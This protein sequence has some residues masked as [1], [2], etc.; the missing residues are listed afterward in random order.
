MRTVI[1]GNSGSGKTWLSRELATPGT[2][3]VHL[4]DLFWL[5][6][7]FNK[8]RSK[9]EINRLIVQS[10]G[11]DKWI[12]EG[13]FGELAKHFLDSANTLIWLDLPW[14]LCRSRLEQRGSESKKHLGREQSEGGLLELLEWASHY[15]N[16]SDLRSHNGHQLLFD[17]FTGDKVQL[18]SVHEVDVYMK[19]AKLCASAAAD[20]PRH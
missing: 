6:G 16:R 14:E 9:E 13:V 17:L 5:P 18:K 12:A 8:K 11:H 4:D 15:Y 10:R 20:K 1:I 3:I 2:E 7:G 19:S